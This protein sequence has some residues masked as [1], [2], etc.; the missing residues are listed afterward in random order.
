M[1]FLVIIRRN[2]FLKEKIERVIEKEEQR[3]GE[4]EKEVKFG[5]RKFSWV[6]YCRERE[7]INGE[8][9]DRA[10]RKKEYREKTGFW[11][12]AKKGKLVKENDGFY[13]KNVKYVVF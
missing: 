1:S 12:G 9:E 13:Y 11:D 10:E 4:R 6:K 8:K 5:E 3:E 2:V 7:D